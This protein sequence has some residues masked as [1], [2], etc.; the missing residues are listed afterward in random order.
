MRNFFDKLLNLLKRDERF[1]ADDGT[2]LRNAVCEAAMTA[3]EKLLQLL[4]SEDFTREKFFRDVAGVKIFDKVEFA[5]TVNNREFLPDNY[6][7]FKNKI[8][9]VDAQE[10]FISANANVVLAFPYKDCVLEGGQTAEDQKRT[11]IFYNELLAPN[12]LDR[13]LEPKVFTNA[14]RY[15]TDSAQIAE[16]FS[17]DDNLI[18]KGNNLLA[19]ASLKKIFAAK[20]KC[21]Y[22]DPPYNTGNDGFGYNDRFNHSTCPRTFAQ[23]RLHLDFYRRRRTGLS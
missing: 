13:L 11:E 19:L 14:V 5:W 16:T 6:T 23:R 18:I 2:F 12:D 4:L 10:N 15:S 3:D 20:V 22:I 17:D 9:L 1:F 8:G 21:I 7:R